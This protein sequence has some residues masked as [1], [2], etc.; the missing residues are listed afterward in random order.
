[1]NQKIK[2]VIMASFLADALSLGVH[3]VYDT[4]EIKKKYGRLEQMVKPE[5]APYHSFKEKG[6][7][8]HYGDQ[9]M[10]GILVLI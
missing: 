9:M 6:E 8:T 7:F 5:I 4:N 1:M 10:K 2:Q 3:W